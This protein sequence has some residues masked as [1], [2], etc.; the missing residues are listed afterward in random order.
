MSSYSGERTIGGLFANEI[1]GLN[2]GG[3][4]SGWGGEL[5]TGN[6]FSLRKISLNLKI[7]QSLESWCKSHRF[8][9]TK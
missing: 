9:N 2:L 7:S 5:I 6:C 1:W 3:L 8:P 4:F